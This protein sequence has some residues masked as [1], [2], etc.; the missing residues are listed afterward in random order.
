MYCKTLFGSIFLHNLFRLKQLVPKYLNLELENIWNSSFDIKQ[1]QLKLSRLAVSDHQARIKCQKLGV[2]L[3]KLLSLYKASERLLSKAEKRLASMKNIA[4][5]IENKP[6]FIKSVTR[7]CQEFGNKS[8]KELLEM[9]IRN[10]NKAGGLKKTFIENGKIKLNSSQ[11]G[12]SKFCK[13]YKGLKKI[14][15]LNDEEE[16]AT[17]DQESLKKSEH[18]KPGKSQLTHK[19]LKLHNQKFAFEK[20]YN[21]NSKASPNQIDA[22]NFINHTQRLS[23]IPGMSAGKMFKLTEVFTKSIGTSLVGTKNNPFL[24]NNMFYSLCRSS[25]AGSSCKDF[26]TARTS[27]RLS[28]QQRKD[29]FSAVNKLTPQISRESLS[30]IQKEFSFSQLSDAGSD[31]YRRDIIDNQNYL[32]DYRPPE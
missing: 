28:Q 18:Q 26:S 31:G 15:E 19:N 13:S 25:V 17:K 30:E 14:K 21:S 11:T 7:I 12:L 16:E 3:M 29:P 9:I 5:F 8:G 4:A 6:D 1:F 23:E 10:N 22:P 32:E 27:Y 2:N 24:Y 20:R